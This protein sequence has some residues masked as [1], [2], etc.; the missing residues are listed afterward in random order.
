MSALTVSVGLDQADRV[1]CAEHFYCASCGHRSEADSYELT[2]A[3][4]AAL[5]A[6]DGEWEVS[7]LGT[8]P[9]AAFQWIRERF[10]TSA[11]EAKARLGSLMRGAIVE[12]ESARR[13]L[14]RLG[15]HAV[16]RRI[17]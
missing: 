17:R 1:H 3:Q 8:P 5:I 10:G 2:M 15:A 6:H 13:A 9:I 4:R 14:V 16:V 7:V 11:V 12:V